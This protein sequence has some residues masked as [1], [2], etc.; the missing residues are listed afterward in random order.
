MII[1]IVVT[2]LYHLSIKSGYGPL[3]RNLPL[4]LGITADEASRGTG[5]SASSKNDVLALEK[6]AKEAARKLRNAPMKVTKFAGDFAGGITGGL[7]RRRHSG[8][9]SLTVQEYR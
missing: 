8:K 3:V 6:Q 2:L 1:L 4:D 7:L 9:L 5:M